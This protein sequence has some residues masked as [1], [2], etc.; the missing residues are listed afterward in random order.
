MGT[1]IRSLKMDININTSERVDII[2]FLPMLQNE[3]EEYLL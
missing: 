1:F 2:E 3:K